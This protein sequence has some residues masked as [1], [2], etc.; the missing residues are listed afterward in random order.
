ME[1]FLTVLGGCLVVFI[2]VFLSLFIYAAIGC[3]LWGLIMVPVFGLPA[4]GYWQMF[5]LMWLLRLL[6]GR[7]SSYSSSKK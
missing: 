1:E 3:W 6:F 2:V 4:L 7:S 5:G